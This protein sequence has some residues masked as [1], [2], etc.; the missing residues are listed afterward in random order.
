MHVAHWYGLAVLVMLAITWAAKDHVVQKLG[1]CLLASWSATQLANAG[2]GLDGTPLFMPS[3]QV[4]LA[5]VV[6]VL[7]FAN[8]SWVALMVFVLYGVLIGV[9]MAAW[10]TQRTGDYFYFATLNVVFLSQVLIVGGASG[11]GAVRRWLLW[12]GERLGS[13]RSNGG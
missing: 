13:L 10:I 2:M 3:V 7:G 8:R 11:A 9:H 12:S 5:I 4:A 1:L 6:A